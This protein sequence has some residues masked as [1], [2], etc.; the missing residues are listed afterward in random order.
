MLFVIC[1]LFCA[2]KSLQL[3]LII[4]NHSENFIYTSNSLLLFLF[5]TFHA[6]CSMHIV[7]CI[8]FV[9]SISLP[10]ILLTHCIS[11]SASVVSIH[12]I[13]QIT[14]HISYYMNL[15]LCLWK[16][17]KPDTNQKFRCL[18]RFRLCYCW[19]LVWYLVGTEIKDTG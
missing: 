4:L 8:K 11:F 10:L 18:Y 15:F 13:I 16:C 9:L 14:L 19:L 6:L 5:I 2:F 17:S 7:L 3:V 1:S 12:S